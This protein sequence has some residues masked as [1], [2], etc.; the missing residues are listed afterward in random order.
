MMKSMMK[1]PARFLFVA[2]V[3]PL[4]LIAASDRPDVPA[5]ESI[6]ASELHA[7]VSFLASD[8]MEGRDTG[9]T[10]NLIAAG[11]LANQ[12]ELLG[13]RPAGDGNTFFQ[14][15]DVIRAR[16][17]QPNRLVLHLPDGG[18]TQAELYEDFYPS[19]LS[20]DGSVTSSIA[21]VGYGITAPELGYDDYGGADLDGRIA[22]VL[23]GADDEEFDAASDPSVHPEYGRESYKLL[24]AQRHGA[25]GVIFIAGGR[26][27]SLDRQSRRRWPEDVATARLQLADEVDQIRI[28][29][30]YLKRDLVQMA[31]GEDLSDLNGEREK[32]RPSMA[33]FDSTASLDVRIE[34]TRIK[35]RNVLAEL[36]GS[37]PLLRQDAVVVSAHL[38][39]VGVQGGRIYN[40]ADDDASGS[41]GVLEIAEAFAQATPAPRRTILLA[42]WNAE[43]QGLLGSRFFVNHPAIPLSRIRAVFQMDMIGRNQEV[44]N[45]DDARF[46]G[47]TRQTASENENTLNLVGYSRSTDLRRLIERANRSIGLRLLCQLDD[48]P[49]QLIR[50]SDSWP[51]LIKGV[52]SMLF[53]TGLH[54]DYHTPGDQASKLNYPKME[55][56]VR[57]I[58]LSARQA[59]DSQEPLRLDH[60]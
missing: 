3:L 32:G 10:E 51:F 52:P 5:V 24:N 14:N 15:F 8:E 58:Y 9:S 23:P 35:T 22:L 60:P 42:I 4:A 53:T 57:L 18:T 13:L 55:R 21:Y 28:P 56:V 19:P 29:A 38:D 11:Y 49:L 12:L 34:R 17:G 41:A 48:Q 43:E 39:H 40:G 54:P 1:H 45:P 30:V 36:P 6:T 46:E 16:L 33:S 37:D 7:I 31:V 50:R 47:M 44:S 26:R 25:G 2:L 20:A 59:A 27:G